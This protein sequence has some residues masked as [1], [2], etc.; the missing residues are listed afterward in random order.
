MLT[1][2][3]LFFKLSAMFPSWRTS[4]TKRCLVLGPFVTVL[5]IRLVVVI[6]T[7]WADVSYTILQLQPG[8]SVNSA[9][10][11]E[12]KIGTILDFVDF[13]LQILSGTYVSG[14]S[15]CYSRSLCYR[16]LRGRRQS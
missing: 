12:A 13:G 11:R 3:S 2:F 5:V 1:Q 15:K 7:A 6:I 16:E 9:I 8:E 14:K 4:H 10:E